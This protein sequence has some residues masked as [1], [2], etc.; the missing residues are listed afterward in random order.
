MSAGLQNA[1]TLREEVNSRRLREDEMFRK[2]DADIS[3]RNAETVYRDRKTGKK[4]DVEAERAA[5]AEKAE[6]ERVHKE[7]FDKWGKG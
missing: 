6:R 2:M 4:R 3:G 1:Q 5:E 7:R